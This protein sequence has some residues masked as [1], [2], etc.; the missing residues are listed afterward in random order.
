MIPRTAMMPSATVSTS[1]CWG[2]IL[3]DR[4]RSR[5]KDVT[6][7]SMANRDPKPNGADAARTLA[8]PAISD[9][10]PVTAS[11]AACLAALPGTGPVQ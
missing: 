11:A 7:R 4:F 6:G 3:C 1:G 2:L 9:V 8:L 5:G 10:P